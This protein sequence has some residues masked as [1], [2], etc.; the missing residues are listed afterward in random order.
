MKSWTVKS[1]SRHPLATPHKAYAAHAI[2]TDCT[3]LM[4]IRGVVNNLLRFTNLD[5]I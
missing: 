2:Q 5:G 1:S 4:A 3:D